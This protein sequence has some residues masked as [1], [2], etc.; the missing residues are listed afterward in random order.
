M[1]SGRQKL[2]GFGD[3]FTIGH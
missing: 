2:K 3:D 1:S